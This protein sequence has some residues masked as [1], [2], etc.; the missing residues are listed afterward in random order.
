MVGLPAGVS[1][2]F[3]SRSTPMSVPVV[4]HRTLTRPSV[5]RRDLIPELGIAAATVAV[6]TAVH[7]AILVRVG[8]NSPLFLF[9][10]TAAALTF[11]RGLGPG[12]LA[13]SL[14]SAI[15]P[16]LSVAPFNEVVRNRGSLQFETLLL[17]AG[18]MFLCWMIYRLRV[19]QEVAQDVQTR[20]NDA[21]A[22]VSHELRQPL[23]NIMLIA[24]ILERD[25]TE[26]TRNRATNLILRSATRLATVVDELADVTRLQ[27]NAIT[28]HPKVLRLQ[29]TI[30]AA[31]EGARP[32]L[33]HKQQSLVTQLTLDR[34]L[35][36]RGDA[37]RLEQVF[38]NL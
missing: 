33:E 16:S 31:I 28:V 18:S 25:S 3:V 9:A 27:G 24:G 35:R 7:W 10:A 12:M 15:G 5:S 37:M 21:L 8:D 36:V 4:R 6:T 34:P 29:D 20:R 1:D 11:W 32:A 13:S 38:D 14:G 23:S 19:A 26:E 30:Q 2:A 17:L 22:F